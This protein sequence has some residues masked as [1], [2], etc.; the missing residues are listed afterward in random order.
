MRG[1]G[2]T[3]ADL[4]SGE[5][6]F[7]LA[8][9]D[10]LGTGATIFAVD[11]D[12]SALERLSMA[13]RKSFPQT[14]LETRIADF[15]RPI[16]LL[17]L[18]GLVIANALHYTPNGGVI[19]LRCSIEEK[20]AASVLV[21]VSDT[22]EGIPPDDLPHIFDRFY[23]SPDSRGSGLGL[24]IARNLVLAHG[25]EISASSVI[26]KGTTISFTL[27]LAIS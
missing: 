8:L 25:G 19:S 11:R 5:G 17:S 15:T 13:M 1:S 21:S 27:P 3:W 18:D 23:K 20:E 2:G 12:R 4:G 7:T 10:L 6:A 9:A 16:D 14:H 26:G 24:T 22:G